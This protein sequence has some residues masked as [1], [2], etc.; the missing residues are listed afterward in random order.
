MG[1]IMTYRR[2]MDRMMTDRFTTV[3]AVVIIFVCIALVATVSLLVEFH[4][5]DAGVARCH[6]HG[7][8]AVTQEWWNG[9]GF[10]KVK[11]VQ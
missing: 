11:C 4:L 2:R 3:M 1:V 6:K 9:E 5:R 7:G 8:V 10:W